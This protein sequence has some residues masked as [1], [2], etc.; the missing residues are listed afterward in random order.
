MK[1]MDLMK[2]MGNVKDEFLEEL[3]EPLRHTR[4][5]ST[6]WKIVLA[7]AVVSLFTMT[8]VAAPAI[9]SKLLGVD[10]EYKTKEESFP[11]ISVC[12]YDTGTMTSGYQ[13]LLDIDADP[14]AP[15][16]LEDA[17]IPQVLLE[18]YKPTRC[19]KHVCGMEYWCKYV[20][21]D[22]TIT[23]IRFEQYVIPPNGS[24]TYQAVCRGIDGVT[25]QTKMLSVEDN[26]VLEVVFQDEDSL[27]GGNR[28]LYWSD[29]MYIYY[30]MVAYDVPAEFYES[31]ITS[32]QLV[33]N[34]DD[35]LFNDAHPPKY[36]P[37]ET[38]N[39]CPN[40]PITGG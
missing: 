15:E 31:V 12:G 4:G 30:L 20:D 37:N 7:A 14:N 32:V 6:V 23:D 10:V 38:E 24:G 2:A 1:E 29:G 40:T 25:A 26:P 36:S 27:D 28:Q 34:I 5:K 21:T 8:A 11:Y 17:Y 13:I 19:A 18:N 35:Y 33:E 22:G 39:Q 3:N 9:R 16:R